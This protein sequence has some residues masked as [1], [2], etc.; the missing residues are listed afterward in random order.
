MIFG[1]DQLTRSKGQQPGMVGYALLAP[2]GLWLLLF[3]V[4]PAAIMLLYSFCQRDELGQ[5]AYSFTLEN[6]RRIFGSNLYLNVLWRS[7]KLAG[8]TTLWCL[9]LGYPAAYYIGRRSVSWR[10]RL[11]LLI[12]L[13][14]WTSFLIRT[15][16][17]ITILKDQGVLN[18][19]LTQLG[20]PQ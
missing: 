3:V 15:Y 13:P 8:E 10:N 18:A 19:T 2:M 1:Q 14:F 17:W 6:Y 4:L 5:V 7:L 11:L 16:A 9:L 12:M 20:L